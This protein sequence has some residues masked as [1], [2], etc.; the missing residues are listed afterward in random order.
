VGVV[1][2][3][4]AELWW[5]HLS[6]E[7]RHELDEYLADPSRSSDPV[8]D[9]VQAEIATIMDEASVAEPHLTD[10]HREFIETQGE[11]VD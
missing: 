10:E 6:I 9:V 11:Q 5:P 1:S 2:L 3:P 7:A 4:D 8:P